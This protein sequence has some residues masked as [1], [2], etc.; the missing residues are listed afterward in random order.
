MEKQKNS[1]SPESS[2]LGFS[3]SGLRE[4][5]FGYQGNSTPHNTIMSKEEVEIRMELEREIENDLQ[6]EIENGMH[7]LALR[8]HQLYKHRRERNVTSFE[9]SKIKIAMFSN[10][11]MSLRINLEEEPPNNVQEVKNRNLEKVPRSK[12][13]CKDEKGK[14]FDNRNMKNF[15]RVNALRLSPSKERN[16]FASPPSIVKNVS[17]ERKKYNGK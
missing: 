5:P 11:G 17:K 15:D 10:S 13:Y 9:G 8:L 4:P 2:L 1:S 16:D 3:S 7:N 12:N 14:Q 6:Q